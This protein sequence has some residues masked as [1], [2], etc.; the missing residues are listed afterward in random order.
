MGEEAP[1]TFGAVLKRYRLRPGWTQEALAERA[2]ISAR[3][4]SDLERGLYRAPQRDT[5]GRR[6]GARGVDAHQRRGVG[7]VA[8]PVPR[9]P[10][11]GGPAR[12]AGRRTHN[13][14]APLTSFVGRED[15]LPAVRAVVAAHLLV[16]LTGPGGTGKTRLARDTG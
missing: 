15:E 10:R 13:L 1:A 6:V 14:P 5:L 4:V 3:A 8:E 11:P 16:T 7:S 9:R 2:G 12:A